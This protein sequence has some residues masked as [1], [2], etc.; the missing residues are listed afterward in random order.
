M[1][2]FQGVKDGLGSKYLTGA[3]GPHRV[4]QALKVDRYY[5]TYAWSYGCVYAGNHIY[6]Y[7]NDVTVAGVAVDRDAV[8]EDAGLWEV[9]KM[10]KDLVVYADGADKR[11][12]EYLADALKA[13]I[14]SLDN[15]TPELL[16]CATST[17][18]V[19]GSAYA[20]AT[21]VSGNNR[22]STMAAVL[23]LVGAI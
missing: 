18:K 4:M 19:G 16:A 1:D 6:Q 12:A 3:Y 5:Q 15:A 14:V 13:P 10:F 9:M 11:A 17:Y 22:F 21:L 7:Q 20:G 23:K 2:Y 8:N